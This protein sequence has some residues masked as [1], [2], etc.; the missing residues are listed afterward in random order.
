MS[1]HPPVW[2]EWLLN[3]PAFFA[4]FFVTQGVVGFYILALMSGWNR[5]SKQ[6]RHEGAFYGETWPFQSARMRTLIRFRC[7]L[8]MGGDESGLYMAVFPLFRMFHPPLLI[9]WSEVSIIPGERGLIFKQRL[10][11]LGRQEA[12]SLSIS[13]SLAENLKG[14]A[15]EA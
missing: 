13:S 1:S 10:L 15:G 3:H 11:L 7:A 6:F 12:I 14:A 9:P 2:I 8:T 5:L 4:L